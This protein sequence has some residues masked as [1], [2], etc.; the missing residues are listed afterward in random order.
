LI[1]DQD[2]EMAKKREKSGE[3]SGASLVLE[4]PHWTRALK[5]SKAV[6]SVLG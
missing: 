4:S 2:W 1:R 6:K 3:S 5:L